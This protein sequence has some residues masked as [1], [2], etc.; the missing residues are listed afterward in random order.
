MCFTTRG[1]IRSLAFIAGLLVTALP[2]NGSDG[3]YKD[4]TI[5]NDAVTRIQVLAIEY[6]PFTSSA[7]A[8]NGVSFV[9]L[10]RILQ[11]HG[12][13]AHAE[14]LPPARVPMVIN[15]SGHWLASFFPP[16]TGSS[17]VEV[18]IVAPAAIRMGLFRQ[19]KTG[20]F[21]WQALSELRD[22]TLATIRSDY[23][24]AYVTPFVKA[25]MNMVFVDSI[26]QGIRMLAEGRVDY[27][28]S[29]EDTGWYYAE[30]HNLGREQL[31]FSDSIIATFPHVLYVNRT[32]PKGLEL[33]PVDTK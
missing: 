3:T 21:S 7:S 9:M 5:I 11:S 27:V 16:K 14:F 26:E 22:N 6:P 28:L 33:G 23:S 12:W 20:E 4:K 10:N 15:Q 2:V 17:H 25:G 31:Q 13:N 19:R 18:V 1:L 32:H 30:L 8:G 24:S 29:I